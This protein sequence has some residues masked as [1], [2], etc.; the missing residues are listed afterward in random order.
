MPLKKKKKQ[1]SPFTWSAVPLL[2][3]SEFA[4]PFEEEPELRKLVKKPKPYRQLDA[5]GN[6]YRGPAVQKPALCANDE[7]PTCE[8]A[9][10]EGCGDNCFNRGVFME[11]K[12]G[13]CQGGAA[14]AGGDCGNTATQTRA[15]PPT[16]VVLTPGCGWGLRVGAAVAKGRPL[17][18]YCG[19]V[20]TTEA[21]RARLG[22][23]K[24]GEDFYFASLNAHLVLDAAQMGSN[25]RYETRSNT[26]GALKTS[27]C[28]HKSHTAACALIFFP[29]CCK[30]REPFVQPQLPAAKMACRRRPASRALRRPGA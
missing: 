5:S 29:L 9:P 27:Q 11:C 3:A 16:E 18:E 26:P 10:G 12:L 13:A 28:A 20:I 1:A 22:S 4:P 14:R 21:C 2:A 6:Y 24:S 19:E 25:A 7:W 15:F 23:L 30:V 8:C 17:V